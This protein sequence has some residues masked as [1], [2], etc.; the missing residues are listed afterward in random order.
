MPTQYPTSP[1]CIVSSVVC[2][3]LVM[4]TR[5]M[6]GWECGVDAETLRLIIIQNKIR[7]DA[8]VSL[9][10]REGF[11]DAD[12]GCIDPFIRAFS[13]LR[14]TDPDAILLFRVTSDYAKKQSNW[15]KVR[16]YRRLVRFLYHICVVLQ[17][18]G[19]L[20]PRLDRVTREEV[21]EMVR[22]QTTSKVKFGFC[23]LVHQF[24]DATQGPDRASC[25][26]LVGRSGRISTESVHFL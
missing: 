8:V 26:L 1:G 17:P 21:I 24:L 6:H 18:T 14:W 5:E 2:W 7:T 13:L 25:E 4:M 10:F 19:C 15:G 20:V 12:N 23:K 3:C 16:Y 22:K 11:E 9:A